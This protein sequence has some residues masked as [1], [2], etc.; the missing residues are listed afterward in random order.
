[1]NKLF[2][3]F[4]NSIAVLAML[5]MIL[6]VLP[7]KASAVGVSDISGHWAQATIQSLVNE[8]IITGFPDGTFKPDDSISRAEFMTIVNRAYG[9]T[10]TVPIAFPDVKT[11]AWYYKTVAI[12]IA[13]GYISG[14][15][16]GTMR[17][18][19]PITRQEAATII[20]RMDNLLQNEAAAN[21]YFDAGSFTWGKG[22]IGA[23][24][25]ANIM[26]GYPNGNF[27]T[28]DYLKRGSAVVCIDRARNYAAG[29]IN[30]MAP[31]VTR[32]DETNKVTGMT[33]MMAYNLD[34]TG[35]VIYNE[36]VFNALNLSGNHSLLV[37]YAAKGIIPFGLSRELLFTTNAV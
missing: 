18:E 24:L 4:K 35:W 37:R 10:A 27:G 23:V 28:Q 36:V 26:A 6:T 8:G 17:P 9:N 22:A 14:L 34:G 13:A 2:T 25:I 29:L 15:S 3:Y 16:D 12:A 33:T 32:N 19:N 5:C 11:G 7:L 31:M 30:P 1:M 20:M 21:S